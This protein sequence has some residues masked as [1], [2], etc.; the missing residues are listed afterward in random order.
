MTLKLRIRGA[1]HPLD[2]PTLWLVAPLRMHPEK[3]QNAV[4][5]E[6]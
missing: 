5:R 2:C 1:T 6:P 4:H 3:L